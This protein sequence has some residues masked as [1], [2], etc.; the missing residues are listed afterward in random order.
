MG[1]W[2]TGY[3][4][5][6]EEAGL[7][8]YIREVKPIY[9]CQHCS[10]EFETTDDLRRHR[11]EDHPYTRPVLMVRGIEL[12]T[13]AYNITRAAV[14]KDFVI[15]NSIKSKFNGKPVKTKNLPEML[16]TV[17][18]DT[19]QID[20]INNGAAAEFKLVFRIA[21]EKHLAGVENNFLK[22]ARNKVLTV[23]TI[24]GFIEDCRPFS[25]ADIYYDGICHYLY[26]VLAKERSPDSSLPYEEYRDRFNRAADALRDYDRSLAHIVRGL[27]AFHFNHFADAQNFAP[28]GRL[29]IVASRFATVLATGNWS[30]VIQRFSKKTNT[31]EDLLT[32][33]ETLRILRWAEMP[34]TELTREIN[35]IAAL[36]ERDVPELDRLKL[37]ILL[38]EASATAANIALAHRTAREMIGNPKTEI[39]AKKLLTRLSL[40]ERDV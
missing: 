16:S 4:E 33:H 19:V 11:F 25:T 29:R 10:A 30:H 22:L 24:D 2:H 3:L 37:K 27:V 5:H 21:E 28:P 32:D 40:E 17:K 36:A 20:L 8:Q 13:T 38:A 35:D 26:G 23:S 15:E 6:H 18:N 9:R 34:L 12:G 31:P 1:F 39:W 7:G 14:P